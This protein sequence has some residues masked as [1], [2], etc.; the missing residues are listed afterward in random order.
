MTIKINDRVTPK[1]Y[2]VVNDIRPGEIGVVQGIE[3]RFAPNSWPIVVNFP[4]NAHCVF[5]ED[6]LDIVE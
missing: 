5:N 1:Y 3:S 2:E 6:E 4:S